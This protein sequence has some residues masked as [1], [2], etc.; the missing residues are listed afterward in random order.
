M[1]NKIDLS[2]LFLLLLIICFQHCFKSLH[3][4]VVYLS[5]Q[6]TKI[7]LLPSKYEIFMLPSNHSFFQAIAILD[8]SLLLLVKL[9]LLILFSSFLVSVLC[10]FFYG[11]LSKVIALKG[12]SERITVTFR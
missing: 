1:S 9:S 5:L 10:F 4:I 3:K 8:F 12:D 2:N 7:L 6:S 11:S